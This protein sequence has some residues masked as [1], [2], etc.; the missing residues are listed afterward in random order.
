MKAP[1]N[2]FTVMLADDELPEQVPARD[3]IVTDEGVLYATADHGAHWRCLGLV[4]AVS[5]LLDSGFEA[6][7]A[8]LADA[9]SDV[10]ARRPK[11][12][13]RS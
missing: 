12:G 7:A 4:D 6:A 11:V 13:S 8:S 10:P 1:S 5:F 3:Y 2:G 9:M